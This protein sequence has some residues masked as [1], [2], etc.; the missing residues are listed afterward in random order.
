MYRFLLKPQW[1]A[2]LLLGLVGAIGMPMLGIWQI[3]RHQVRQ[4]ENAQIKK[5]AALAAMPF[6]SA[7]PDDASLSDGTRFEWQRVALSGTY[8]PVHQVLIDNRS[9]N[10][11]PGY[12]VVTPLRTDDGPTVLINRGWIPKEPTVDSPT[13]NPAA[14]TE[15]VTIEG[16]IRATQTK[17]ALTPATPTQ[18]TLAILARVDIARIG[19]QTPDRLAPVYV[20]TIN[21]SPRSK[22]SPALIP[23]RPLD[24][25]SSL[26]YAFQWFLFTAV[27]LITWPLIIRR[28]LRKK[29][30]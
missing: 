7:V 15:R 6:S 13:P 12:H 30:T 2:F 14:T 1:I 10:G 25:G 3:N 16:R 5:R 24:G 18:G 9:L 19:Q 11:R 8:D 26:S 28:E 20:E 4:E 27:G 23:E 29:R 21:E 17:T 22:D